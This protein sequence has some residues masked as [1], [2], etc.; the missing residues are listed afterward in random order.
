MASLGLEPRQRRAE[1][2]VNAAAERVM[3]HV[4]SRD[5][6]AVGLRVNLRIAIRGGEQRDHRFAAT[7]RAAADRDVGR[8]DAR[9]L[10]HRRLEAQNLLDGV[11][12][13]RGVVAQLVQ[14][15]GVPEQDPHAVAD[16]IGRGHVAGDQQQ[17]AHRHDLVRR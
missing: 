6:E 14:L 9:A 2:E 8:R 7:H 11:V 16:E 10:H 4:R 17:L 15:L 13:Q 12:D 3:V 5:V 1:A